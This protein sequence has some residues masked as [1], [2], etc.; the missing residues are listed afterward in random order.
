MDKFIAELL[1]GDAALNLEVRAAADEVMSH[2][3]LHPQPETVEVAS[4]SPSEHHAN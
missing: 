1:L 3:G 4:Q 2:C